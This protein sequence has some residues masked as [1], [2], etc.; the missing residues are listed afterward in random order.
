M[1]K[2]PNA[3]LAINSVDRFIN[4]ET[5]VLNSFFAHFTSGSTVL[6]YDGANS[7]PANGVPKVGAEL[8]DLNS[9]FAAGTKIDS[10]V[11][12]IPGVTPVPPAVSQIIISKPPLI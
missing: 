9:N 4:V 11:N 8:S 1:S 10:L 6:N 2:A 12:V 5:S 3:I 7:N